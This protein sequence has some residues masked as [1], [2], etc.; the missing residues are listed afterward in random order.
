[1]CINNPTFAPTDICKVNNPFTTFNQE[2]YIQEDSAYES[3]PN[4]VEIRN[5]NNNDDN[6]NVYKN[7][8]RT[9]IKFIHDKHFLIIATY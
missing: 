6:D 1:M 2:N 7:K 5:N 9:S 4:V 3:I 8:V